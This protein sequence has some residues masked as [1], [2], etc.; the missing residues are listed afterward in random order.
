[1]EAARA[2][3]VGWRAGEV[4][5]RVGPTAW[6]ALEILTASVI[7]GHG[8]DGLRA[9]AS[10]RSVAA[11]LGVSKNAA[12][13]ALRVLCASGFIV[14]AQ[15]RS[16]DGRFEIGIYDLAIPAQIIGPADAASPSRRMT[17]ARSSLASSPALSSPAPQV[18][19]E[20]LV[21]L[22]AQ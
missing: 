13:R 4:R 9:Q 19:V 8:G 1:M 10:V 15:R 2:V 7:E 12:H 3:T 21:L 18:V 6:C 11:E 22:P 17:S 5:R 16:S 14:A 20:Q